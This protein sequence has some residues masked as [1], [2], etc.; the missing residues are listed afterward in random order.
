MNNIKS[1]LK[2]ALQTPKTTEK[3]TPG[4]ITVPNKTKE[5]E[6]ILKR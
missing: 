3:S 4:D 5:K 2:G 6:K 1:Y